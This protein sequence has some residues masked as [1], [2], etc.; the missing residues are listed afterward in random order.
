MTRELGYAVDRSSNTDKM[1]QGT[2][3]RTYVLLW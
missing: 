1:Y 2:Q 3:V